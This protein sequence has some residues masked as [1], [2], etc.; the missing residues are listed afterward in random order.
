LLFVRTLLVSVVQSAILRYVKLRVWRDLQGLAIG[1]VGS[2]HRI[3]DIGVHRVP[4]EEYAAGEWLYETLDP[5]AEMFAMERRKTSVSRHVE[6]L[7]SA[8]DATLYDVDV[9]RNQLGIFASDTQLV[10]TVYYR[11]P[12]SLDQIARHLCRPDDELVAA[13]RARRNNPDAQGWGATAPSEIHDRA[14]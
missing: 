13:M 11:H 7:L 12:A 2:A 1:V 9:W 6:R 5:A 4:P 10:H 14:E 3:E 8:P